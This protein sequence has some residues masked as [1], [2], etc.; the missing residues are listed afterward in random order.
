MDEGN[1]W[2]SA[3]SAIPVT[4]GFAFVEISNCI[5]LGN[6]GGIIAVMAEKLRVCLD[7]IEWFAKG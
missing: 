6:G 3:H 4:S 7:N 2:V 1:P 5:G